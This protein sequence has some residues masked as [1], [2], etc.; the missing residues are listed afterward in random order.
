M[1][2][3]KT[4]RVKWQLIRFRDDKPNAKHG[5]VAR[6]ILLSIEEDPEIYIVSMRSGSLHPG[7]EELRIRLSSF[8]N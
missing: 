8:E 2:H 4:K 7:K 1:P 3:E 6:E 5:S